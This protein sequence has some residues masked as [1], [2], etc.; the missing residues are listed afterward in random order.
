MIK[1]FEDFEDG[2]SIA[3]YHGLN[4]E[5]SPERSKLLESVGYNDIYY[6]HIDFDAEWEKDKGK[7]LFERELSLL[8]GIDLI[9]GFSL[10]GYLAFE[11]AGHLS[12]NLILINPALDRSKTKLDIKHFDITTKRQFGKIETFLGANDY[13][14][15]KSITL[16]YLKENNIKSDITIIEGMEHRTPMNY[17]VEILNKS[18]L[19]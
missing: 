3:I 16:N 8:R 13:L 4:G 19:I 11:L 18:N 17:F 9:M 1:K 14:V 12:T 6:P 5:P 10:G 2:K 7:S 15:D